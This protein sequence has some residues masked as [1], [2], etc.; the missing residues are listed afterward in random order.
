MG[1]R[2]AAVVDLLFRN[3]DND[4]SRWIRYESRPELVEDHA[5]RSTQAA[6]DDDRRAE[7]ARPDVPVEEVENLWVHHLACRHEMLVATRVRRGTRDG[8]Q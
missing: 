6:A 1:A 2:G 3:T 7:H 8:R 4:E 5:H